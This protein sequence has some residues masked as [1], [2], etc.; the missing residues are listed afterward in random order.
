MV[1]LNH[2]RTRQLAGLKFDQ[3]FELV[4]I[5]LRHVGL[6]VVTRFDVAEV[7]KRELGLNRGRYV[8]LGVSNASLTHRAVRE[9]CQAGLVLP[10]RVVVREETRGSVVVS[11]ED[12]RAV[13]ALMGSEGLDVLANEY[14]E[15]LGEFLEL[16]A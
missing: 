8:V 14:A 2:G 16:L 12:P 7:L 11:I 9:D 10:C 5:T 4:L 15:L 13:F 3:A 6:A 1:T